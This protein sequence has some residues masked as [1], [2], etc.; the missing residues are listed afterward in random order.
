MDFVVNMFNQLSPA[1]ESALT[2]TVTDPS[3]YYFFDFQTIS[4]AADAVSEYSFAWDIPDVAGTYVVEVSLVPS[5]LTAY[6]ALWLG[7]G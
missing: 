7:V 6:D 4:V 3:G 5:M 1:L 2:L